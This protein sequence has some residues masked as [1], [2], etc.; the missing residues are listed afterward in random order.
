FIE[1]FGV[2]V[3]GRRVRLTDGVE[4]VAAGANFRFPKS[5]DDA[6]E[7]RGGLGSEQIILFAS[8]EVFDAARIYRGKNTADRITHAFYDS[9]SVGKIRQPLLPNVL[10]K[11]VTIETR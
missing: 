4:E 9:P 8:T 11:T 5:A 10:K 1:L 2:S 3:D 7:I 6:I